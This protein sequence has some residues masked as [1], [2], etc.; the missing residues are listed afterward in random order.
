MW[1]MAFW[2]ETLEKL[3]RLKGK[4]SSSAMCWA[5]AGL[6]KGMQRGG[7]RSGERKRGLKER[8]RKGMKGYWH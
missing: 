6:A 8:A 3:R 5:I 4:L 1:E 7:T 2:T